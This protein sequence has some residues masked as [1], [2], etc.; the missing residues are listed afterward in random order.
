M[1]V[2]L[3]D[4]EGGPI[5]SADWIDESVTLLVVFLL[6]HVSHVKSDW[7]PYINSLPPCPQSLWSMEPHLLSILSGSELLEKI[8]FVQE[9]F[10]SVATVIRQMNLPLLSPRS[11]T[12]EAIA[13]GM[14]NVE[15]RKHSNPRSQTESWL[16][17]GIGNWLFSLRPSLSPMCP[18]HALFEFSAMFCGLSYSADR[19]IWSSP[20]QPA[21]TTCIYHLH[22]SHCVSLTSADMVNH[23]TT[24]AHRNIRYH[25]S[26]T[27]VAMVT[28]AG[29]K[30]GEQLFQNY[31][32][33]ITP[34]PTSPFNQSRNPNPNHP[35]ISSTYLTQAKY[36]DLTQRVSP[37]C[38]QQ[39]YSV[40]ASV[41]H[42]RRSSTTVYFQ[43]QC[44]PA[45][46]S[47]ISRFRSPQGDS[48]LQVRHNGNM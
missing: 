35:T 8:L 2:C 28:I 20:Y 14:C 36:L 5:K 34:T 32:Q 21:S 44:L 31:R 1:L 15:R 33:E 37:A 11:L 17:P 38:N 3:H 25:I 18:Q 39:R 10:K 12:D 45:F 26:N 4:P 42:G 9:H 7:E 22:L 13:W 16:L 24:N 48:A 40:P 47:H 6:Y 41:R 23:P 19:I 30:S 27:T 46:V 29:I 43:T